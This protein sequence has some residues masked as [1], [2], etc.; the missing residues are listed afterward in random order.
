MLILLRH[1]RTEANARGLLLG[2]RD[3][4]LD[5]LGLRQAEAAA[6]V[7]GRV[8]AVFTSPLARC[9]ETAAAFG[10]ETTV[11][12]AWVELDYGDW[13]GRPVADVSTETWGEW[14]A[15]PHYTPPNGESLATLD[16][17]VHPGL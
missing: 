7:I 2:R 11:D 1:G 15:D 8:D 5:D 17:R 10:V 4:S 16:A 6:E 12:E 14:R 13:D 3:P 9:R